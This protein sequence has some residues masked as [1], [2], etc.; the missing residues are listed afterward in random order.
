MKVLFAVHEFP[1]LGGGAGV[2]IRTLADAVV[3]G[4]GRAKVLTLGQPGV[5]YA[6]LPYPVEAVHSGRASTAYGDAFS[7]LR[8]AH[9]LRGVLQRET[10]TG[11]WDCVYAH[12]TVPA[13]WA[14]VTAGL[15]VP[16]IVDISGADIY[17]PERFA[18]IRPLLN[19][20]NRQVVKK[21]RLV[22]A[23]SKDM[24]QRCRALTGVMPEVVYRAVDTERFHPGAA[25]PQL[26]RHLGVPEG[27]KTILTV[28]RLVPRK[29]LAFAIA[30]TAE[31]VKRGEPVYHVIAG[32]GPERP[33]LERL[34]AACG[35]QG[36]VV[37]AG[38]VP[39]ADLPGLVAAANLFLLTSHYEALG[40]VLLEALAAGT[41][42]LA[43]AIGGITEILAGD[44]G[45]M[46]LQQ[47]SAAPSRW[48]EQ[49]TKLLAVDMHTCQQR[50]S[51]FGVAGQVHGWRNRI[52]LTCRIPE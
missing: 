19:M 37:F 18:L 17:D 8:Y 46:M 26:L 31:L 9:K 27:A 52:S 12:F 20:L 4:G 1:P 38:R 24:A 32:E 41:P 10:A 29:N 36:R 50:A 42:V 13:G 39:D 33:R 23:P 48:A 51:Q 2:W 22:I 40:I 43:P 7:L 45:A 14:A 5:A 25:N 15:N 11:D 6:A 30:V 47:L 44:D 34:V 21:A 28:G 3:A 16:V 49:V 35:L